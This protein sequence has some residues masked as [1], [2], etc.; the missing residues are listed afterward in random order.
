MGLRF[1]LKYQQSCV[2]PVGSR[3]ENPFPCLFQL[4]EISPFLDSLPPSSIFKASNIWLSSSHTPL[5]WFSFLL[6]SST[7]R[8]H[9]ITLGPSTEQQL[10]PCANLIF[11]ARYPNYCRLYVLG[12]EHH[13]G[14][15]SS[16]CSNGNM[17]EQ[18]GFS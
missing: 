4:L 9:V 10:I 2:P 11:L 18:H 6:P 8:T 14:N 16:S 1:T 3:G 15:H 12:C 7:F 5:P 17:Q 13:S